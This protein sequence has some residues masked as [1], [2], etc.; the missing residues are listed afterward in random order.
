MT[1]EK[2][3]HLAI[4]RKLKEKKINKERERGGRGKNL[5]K[6]VT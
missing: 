1:I 3:W 6:K 2:F 4:T 5:E